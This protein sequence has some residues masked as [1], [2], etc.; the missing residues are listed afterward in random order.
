M[1]KQDQDATHLVGDLKALH[2]LEERL[3]KPPAVMGCVQLYEAQQ[4]R[5]H[6]PDTRA[7]LFDPMAC[8]REVSISV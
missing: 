3:P 6:I 1:P 2:N 7:R 8:H 5:L 4:C